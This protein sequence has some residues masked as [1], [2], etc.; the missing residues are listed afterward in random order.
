M[1]QNRKKNFPKIR[2]Y[3]PKKNIF[4]RKFLYYLFFFS[5]RYFTRIIPNN[6]IQSKIKN[7]FKNYTIFFKYL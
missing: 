2:K 6:F 1:N 4:D 3:V 5:P 7:K